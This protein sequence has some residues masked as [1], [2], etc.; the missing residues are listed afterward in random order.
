MK[1][2][3]TGAPTPLDPEPVAT[4][5]I[6]IEGDGDAARCR[7][8]AKGE[9][10]PAGTLRYVTHFFTCPKADTFRGKKRQGQG[11]MFADDSLPD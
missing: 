4:G 7:V 2:A 8:L 10:P 11:A 5:N 3:K 1:N 6:V 9:E